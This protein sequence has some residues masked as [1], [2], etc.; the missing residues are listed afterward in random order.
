MTGQRTWRSLRV[1]LAAICVA[2][3]AI[4]AVAPALAQAPLAVYQLRRSAGEEQIRAALH[5]ATNIDFVEQ[6]LSEVVQFLEDHHSIQIEIDGKALED[7]AVSM[8]TPITRNLQNIPLASALNLL[9]KDLDLDYIISNDVLLIT[10]VDVAQDETELRLYNVSDLDACPDTL[11]EMIKAMY[12]HRVDQGVLKVSP[13]GK[14][15]VIRDT[16]R[17]HDEIESLLQTLR[18][19]IAGVAQPAPKSPP[20]P[21]STSRSKAQQRDAETAQRPPASFDKPSTAVDNPFE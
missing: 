21:S 3:G 19:A 16:Q 6:P 13:V 14:V 7:A 17:G 5:E 8:D 18:L 15:L 4:L 9:L 11:A 12:D 2:G 10:N 1:H 20:P